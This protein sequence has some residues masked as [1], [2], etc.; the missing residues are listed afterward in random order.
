MAHTAL[1]HAAL[2]D[3]ALN[4]VQL[5]IHQIV[6]S[7]AMIEFSVYRRIECVLFHLASRSND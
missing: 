1:L 5:K 6:E 3:R 2:F 7:T 4:M